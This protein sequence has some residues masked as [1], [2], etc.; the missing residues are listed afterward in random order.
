MNVELRPM[1]GKQSG[2]TGLVRID[3]DRLYVDG[4]AVGFLTSGQPA[5]LQIHVTMDQEKAERIRRRC[6]QLSGRTIPLVRTL[7]PPPER[8]R[9]RFA[10]F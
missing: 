4:Q 6:E 5:W 3:Q 2:Q 10:D 8:I 7:P 9:A 1:T